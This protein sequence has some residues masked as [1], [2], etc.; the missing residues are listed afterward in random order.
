MNQIAPWPLAGAAQPLIHGRL[1]YVTKCAKCHAPEPVTKYSY[2]Q[3][4]VIM[5]DM[6]E[7]TKLNATDAAA[8]TSYVQSLVTR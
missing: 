1:I 4:Q 7:E 3:W 8:V 6:I 2:A 5:P